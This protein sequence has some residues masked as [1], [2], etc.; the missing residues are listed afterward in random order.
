MNPNSKRQDLFPCP[1]KL[2]TD[3]AGGGGL[4]VLLYLIIYSI[5]TK[6]Y[7]LLHIPIPIIYIYMYSSPPQN[8]SSHLSNNNKNLKPLQ[9]KAFLVS[10]SVNIRINVNIIIG[11][12]ILVKNQ[13]FQY[14]AQPS[15][16]NHLRPS[17]QQASPQEPERISPKE[18]LTSLNPLGK[19][20]SQ[21]KSLT[22]YRISAKAGKRILN[23]FKDG[24]SLSLPEFVLR[25]P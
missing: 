23:G 16:A 15:L 21:I 7:C 2:Q 22:Y 3:R 1:V 19:I 14:L 8:Q 11:I 13:C 12:S 20:R 9:R 6:F 24:S 25:S 17:T 10:V 5:G 4:I 18:T